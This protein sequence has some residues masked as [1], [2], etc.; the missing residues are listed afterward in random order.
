MEYMLGV[1]VG[2][3]NRGYMR[4][5]GCCEHR[6]TVLGVGIGTCI[7][8]RYDISE[9]SN[10]EWERV[11]YKLVVGIGIGKRGCVNRQRGL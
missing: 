2:I 6:M 3:G 1:G 11:Y 5:Q 7:R 9:P 8:N 4:E 10:M